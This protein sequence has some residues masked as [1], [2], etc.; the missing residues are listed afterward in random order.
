[1]IRYGYKEHTAHHYAYMTKLA[2]VREP[3]GYAEASQD[4]K[5]RS[6]MDS[7]EIWALDANK[8]WDLVD[9]PQ[10]CKPIR[11]KWVYKIKYNVDGSVNRYKILLVAKGYAQT[12]DIKYDDNSPTHSMN[13]TYHSCIRIGE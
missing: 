7:E 10:H 8:T 12:H 13:H 11:C 9:Q 2:E 3:E 6:T 5:W 1:M 4:A